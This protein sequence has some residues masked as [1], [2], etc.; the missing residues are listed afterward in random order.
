LNVCQ[1]RSRG[2][3]AWVSAGTQPAHGDTVV[4]VCA[5]ADVGVPPSRG[6]AATI[7]DPVPLVDASVVD[8][9]DA[10]DATSFDVDV[11]APGVVRLVFTWDRV[12]DGILA[13]MSSTTAKTTAPPAKGA[14]RKAHRRVRLPTIPSF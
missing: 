8:V 14:A 11:E 7:D 13:T 12:D 10:G 5:G 1:Q 3:G 2:W 6:D 9:E 4:V